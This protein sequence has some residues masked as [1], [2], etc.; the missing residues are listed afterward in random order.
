MKSAWRSMVGFVGWE[1]SSGVVSLNETETMFQ[2]AVTLLGDR[3][4]RQSR[5]WHALVHRLTFNCSSTIVRDK[6]PHEV[7]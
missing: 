3:D 4:C 5:S 6:F 1:P 7:Q 2:F